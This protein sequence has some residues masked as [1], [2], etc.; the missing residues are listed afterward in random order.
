MMAAVP[1]VADVLLLSTADL[2]FRP[3]AARNQGCWKHPRRRHAGGAEDQA[4]RRHRAT[5]IEARRA[6][7]DL[8]FEPRSKRVPRPALSSTHFVG[9]DRGAI[10]G[11][12]TRADAR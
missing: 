11:P 8:L 1:A 9:Q 2:G 12:P 7:T 10:A 6:R 3:P 4:T 5:G